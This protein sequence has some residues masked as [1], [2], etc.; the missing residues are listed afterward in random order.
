MVATASLPP[1]RVGFRRLS[2][3]VYISILLYLSLSLTLGQPTVPARPPGHVS[4]AYPRSTAQSP[5][6][7]VVPFTRWPS[8]DGPPR[9]PRRWEMGPS[10][11][12]SKGSKASN[13]PTSRLRGMFSQLRVGA[14]RLK[15]PSMTVRSSFPSPVT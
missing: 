11:D 1:Y 8:F 7:G 10:T 4:P 5:P 2:N 14:A 15:R 9:A 13:G 6:L 12:A 3:T